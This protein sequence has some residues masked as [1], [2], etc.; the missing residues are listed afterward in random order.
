MFIVTFIA[1]NLEDAILLCLC[2][3]DTSLK[4]L[5]KNFHTYSSI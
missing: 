1:Y 2:K 5:I 4:K 3:Q